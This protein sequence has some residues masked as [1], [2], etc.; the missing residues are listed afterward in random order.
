MQTVSRNAIKLCVVCLTALMTFGVGIRVVEAA[1]PWLHLWAYST[2]TI[3]NSQA[4]NMSTY[5]T[6]AANDYSNNTDLN[7]TSSS[8]KIKAQTANYGSLAQ[9]Q[10][11]TSP[12][13][14]SN[15]RCY[16]YPLP[17]GTAECNTTD[18]KATSAIIYFNTYYMGSDKDYL[19]RHEMGHV[20][21]LYHPSCSSADSVMKA[22][23]C[24][25][26]K[27]LLQ[28]DEKNW[29]NSNY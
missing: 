20:F 27:K 28:A 9:Y 17:I 7:S 10:G 11:Y 12:A 1:N 26:P 4:G 16:Y 18:K 22:P 23:N 5:M 14:S 29:I 8:G 21:G 13:N 24:G 3:E 2:F 15:K 25:T 19:A 6:N